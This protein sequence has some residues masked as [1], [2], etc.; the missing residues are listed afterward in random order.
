M[1]GALRGNGVLALH[2]AC[3]FGLAALLAAFRLGLK[4]AE[5]APPWPASEMYWLGVGVIAAAILFN[6]GAVVFYVRQVLRAAAGED[7]MRLR[8]N[9]AV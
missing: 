6:T 2:T 5:P 8:E 9:R 3:W 1:R 4:L 7:Q